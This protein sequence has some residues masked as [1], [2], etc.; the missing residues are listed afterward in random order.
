MVEAA[1]AGEVSLRSVR[2]EG[3]Y[4]QSL[5]Y[6][7]L[8]YLFHIVIL[9]LRHIDT[10]HLW[11]GAEA[12]YIVVASSAEVNY[13]AVVILKQSAVIGS[14]ELIVKLGGEVHCAIVTDHYGSLVPDG[15]PM[16][17][18]VG[19]A[20][21]H[22]VPLIENR[23]VGL[24]GEIQ[25]CMDKLGLIVHCVEHLA[26]PQKLGYIKGTLGVGMVQGYVLL[27]LGVLLEYLKA[28]FTEFE[29]ALSKAVINIGKPLF[30]Y[31]SDLFGIVEGI[32]GGKSVVFSRH[33]EYLGSED[34]GHDPSTVVCSGY[35]IG[36]GAGE[37]PGYGL[38]LGT[39]HKIEIVQC[40][41][42]ISKRS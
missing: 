3:K 24:A 8:I 17:I 27:Y 32:G 30:H 21:E 5:I 2:L 35:D 10:V 31:L 15:I 38:H 11:D 9:R 4:L 18:H 29:N 33:F 20:G 41:G 42:D 1:L 19:V 26:S 36:G 13:S 39:K 16:R 6:G 7:V 40:I 23:T 28:H 37:R 34:G 14:G 12:F 22:T 25:H